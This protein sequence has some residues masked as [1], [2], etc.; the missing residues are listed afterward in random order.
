MTPSPTE[1]EKVEIH[2][3]GDERYFVIDRTM[4][5]YSYQQ[6][7]LL[8]TLNAVQET[9][10]YLSP[11]L[12]GYVSSQLS[13]PL[14]QV[15]G[16]ATFYHMYTL[17]P[18]KENRCFICS[19]PACLIAGSE[20]VLAAAQSLTEHA[21]N[22][23]V[24]IEP[25]SCLG[26]CDQGPAAL[27]NNKAYVDIK[28][29]GVERLFR[30]EAKPSRLQVSGDP[31]LMTRFV[32]QLGPTDLESHRAEG[33][34]AGLEKA[35]TKMSPEKVIAE[36][37]VSGLTGRGGAGFPTGLKWEFTRQAIAEPKYVVCNFDESEPGT[38][39]DRLLME[40]D[41]FRVL[42]GI[43]LSGYAVGS[44]HGYIF[45]RGEY[46]QAAVIIQGAIDQMIQAGLLGKNILGTDF[47]FDIEIRRSAGAYICGEET[48]L[49]EAI[50]GNRG[51][52]RSKPPFPTTHGLFGKPTTINN[53]ETLAIIPDLV[54]NGGSWWHQWG[55]EKSV[56]VK[57][58]CLSGHVNEPGVVEA[59]YG[60]SIR[61]LIEKHAG[62]FFGEPQA[63][64]MGGA[65]GGFLHSDKLDTPL[66]NEDLNP[67]GT[68]IGSGVIMVFNQTV[69][70]MEVFKS[71][72]RFFVNETCGQCVPCRVGT[73]QV[74]RLLEK[75]S[76]GNGTVKDIGKLENLCVSMRSVGECG[77]GQTAPN[78]ILTALQN[79]KP[80]FTAQL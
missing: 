73:T 35:L 12:L 75:I 43:L 6:D 39:K 61:Q 2:P 57:L 40:G 27:L 65:A 23:G 8:E 38:F 63:I 41:P 55:T 66:T 78:P 15:Y 14:S 24:T 72:A 76:S 11:D 77:L 56:G 47:S 10:G 26:L 69:N 21:H 22:G 1:N 32:G 19:D 31:R 52:P 4:E 17:E 58:F 51:N 53:V 30:G 36:V 79:F 16:V 46:P 50:E 48:A 44:S 59:P 33:A 64:L 49:F 60:L 9:F 7:A 3:S 67:L 20:D 42:E 54:I 13:I 34:F 5:R 74:Y 29:E 28:P 18:T 45:I 68:P 37:K 25:S 71:V 70:L 80:E 62:G